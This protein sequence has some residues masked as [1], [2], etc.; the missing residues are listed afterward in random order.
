MILKLKRITY[1]DDGVYDEFEIIEDVNPFSLG[2][3]IRRELDLM[4]CY[5]IE[6]TSLIYLNVDAYINR[7]RRNRYEML[8]ID[9]NKLKEDIII[10]NRDKELYKLIPKWE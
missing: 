4:G 9:M 6:N 7:P 2:K 8:F 10:F 1:E 5:I 3:I